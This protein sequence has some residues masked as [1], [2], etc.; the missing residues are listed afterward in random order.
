MKAKLYGEDEKEQSEGKAKSVENK[1]GS[2]D[3]DSSAIVN[4]D[5]NSIVMNM[6]CQFTDVKSIMCD[7]EEAYQPQFVKIEEE[8]DFFSGDESC[9]F[10]SDD[11]APTLQWYCQD[12]WNLPDEK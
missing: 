4:E 9:N 1:E 3:S 7:A 8:C 12:Q 6:N 11:Q 2:S 10:F 5:N